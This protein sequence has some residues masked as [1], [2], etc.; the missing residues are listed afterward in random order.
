[1]GDVIPFKKPKL[2]DKFKGKT[3]CREGFHKWAIVTSNKFDVKAGRLVT[4]YK[5]SRCG[6]QKVKAH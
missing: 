5:C 6:E 3:L 4:V 2:K 1:M